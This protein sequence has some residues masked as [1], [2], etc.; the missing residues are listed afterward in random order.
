MVRYL[1]H[2]LSKIAWPCAWGETCKHMHAAV[3]VHQK[4]SM[5]RL[6]PS[7]SK[8][9]KNPDH[10]PWIWYVSICLSRHVQTI[11]SLFLQECVQHTWPLVVFSLPDPPMGVL[12]RY[13]DVSDTVQQK[14]S[15]SVWRYDETSS[16]SEP[17]HADTSS[18]SE[19]LE[20][21]CL[22]R[23]F[24]KGCKGLYHDCIQRI[25][26]ISQSWAVKTH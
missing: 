2:A 25:W 11:E 6:C 19:L 14:P 3:L 15:A 26:C 22:E 1:R 23:M 21:I 24:S 7:H 12:G 13:D 8:T 9:N 5:E 4:I 16:E 18:D 10:W 17:H 20:R